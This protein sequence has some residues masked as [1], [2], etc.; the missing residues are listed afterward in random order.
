ME[1]YWYLFDKFKNNL[2]FNNLILREFVFNLLNM[3]RLIVMFIVF[4]DVKY[5]V[6]VVF[7]KV[8]LEVCLC[9]FEYFV[10]FLVFWYMNI[11]VVLYL[12]LKFIGF[13]GLRI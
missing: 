11:W 5:K 9:I 13:Y 12:M 2:V 4:L 10:C 1:V 8:I 6:L 3:S 7:I